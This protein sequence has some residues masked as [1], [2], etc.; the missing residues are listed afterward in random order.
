MAKILEKAK[1]VGKKAMS[2]T[3]KVAEKVVGAMDIT[4]DNCNKLM[5]PG[6]L[7]PKR[8]VKG[9]EYQFC[10]EKC[11]NNFVAKNR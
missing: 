9:R 4:C 11:A 2:R 6:I 8:E 7:G 1:D 10:S 3:K 5:K